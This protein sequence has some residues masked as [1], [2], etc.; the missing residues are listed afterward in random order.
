MVE[1][2][3]QKILRATKPDVFNVLKS[4]APGLFGDKVYSDVDFLGEDEDISKIII[5]FKEE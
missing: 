3:N 5:R 2:K 4:V 1:S